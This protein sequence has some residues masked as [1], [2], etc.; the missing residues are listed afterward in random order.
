MT[1]N[2]LLSKVFLATLCWCT[3]CYVDAWGQEVVYKT[4]LF[5]KNYNSEEVN[6]YYGTNWSSTNNGFT[7]NLS[8]FNNNQNEWNY[9]KGGDTGGSSV[10]TITTNSAIDKSISKVVVTV[11]NVNTKEMNGT[12]LKVASDAGFTQNVQTI[13]VAA[14]QGNLT[15]NVP[16][17]SR[18]L[19]Y[20]LSFD[21]KKGA[22]NGIITI[23][24]VD[25]YTSEDVIPEPVDATWSIVPSVS[26]IENKNKSVSLTTNYDGE[27]VVSSENDAIAT[28]SYSEGNLT[29]H[30]VSGGTTRILFT[31]DATEN[32]NAINKY[33]NVTVIAASDIST[34]NVNIVPNDNFWG[35]N[36]GGT[37]DDLTANGLDITS[38]Q[39]GVTVQMKNN[40]ADAGYINS[41][42]TRVYSNYTMTF[43]VPVGYV[44]TNIVFTPDDS[45]WKGS[46][47]ATVG[48]MSNDKKSWTGKALEVTIDFYDQC[49]IIGI[50]VTVAEAGQVAA[51]IQTQEGYGT[52][53]S[54]EA[55]VLPN[56]VKAATAELAE[57]S[58]V[59]NW[60]YN[61]GDIVPANTPVL[62]NG[63]QG[64]YVMYQTMSNLTKPA[65]NYLFVN[66]GNSSA[67]AE[68]IA[69]NGSMFYALAY[70]LGENANKLGFYWMSE[71]GASFDVPA[72]K[73]FLALP[74][75][76][77]AKAR[78]LFNE[79]DATAIVNVQPA[80]SCKSTDV[81]NLNGQKVDSNFKGIIIRDGKKWYNK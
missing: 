48:T 57:E 75:G 68:S 1:K 65:E 59:W 19:Y 27:L 61:A 18:N 11:D 74:S 56:G 40:A 35:T 41:T 45:Y 37:I 3:L 28:A 42:Q 4:A 77:E 55:F 63:A 46:H 5:G 73:V 34:G 36:Y 47:K 43:S 69:T 49:R 30:G 38:V 10:C 29:I 2:N 62:L 17:S 78:I 23:S 50:R 58:L 14:A 8:N 31:G 79:E 16:N 13:N 9:I 6:G 54:K 12:S 22:A 51:S 60:R 26:L 76:A 21:C 52:F 7:V 25:F 20:K 24:R 71:N 80:V 72:G 33:L 70:G 32:Y 53:C 15:Y 39:E 44:I 67:S 81:Y 66:S 64:G